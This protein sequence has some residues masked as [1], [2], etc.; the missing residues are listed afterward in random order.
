MPDTIAAIATIQ[1]P[2][3]IG[4]VRLTGPDTRR[5]L[6]GVFAPANGRPMS[7]QTPRKLVFGR[8]LDRSGGVIDEALAVL[9]PGPNSYTGEDCAEIHCHGSPVVLDEVLAAAFARGARQARGGEF[10]QRAFLSGRMDLIQAE[11]V[12][13]LIDAESAGAARNAV[14]QLQGRM[15]RSVGGIYDALMDVVSRFYAI[16]D[17]PDEEIEPLQQAQIEQTL[18]ESAERL[19][20][21]LATFSRGRLLKSGVPAVILGK[22]NAGKSSLLNALLGYDRA[23]VT[24]IAGTTRDTVEEKVLVGSVLLR[25]CDTAGIRE[26]ADTVE[27][28]GVERAQQAAQR[29][30]LALLVLDGSAPLT[31]EDEEAIAAARRARRM[32][33][34]VNKAD[35][36]QVLDTAALRVR[37]GEVI[38]ISARSGAGVDALCRAV[39]E[40]FAGGET[41]RGELLTNARQA[42]SAQRALDA[43]RRAEQALRSGLSPDAVLTDAEEALE[44]LAEF[45]GERSVNFCGT[46]FFQALICYIRSEKCRPR[47][48]DST[49]KRRNFY[50]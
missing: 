24:D 1:A 14:G 23:I 18:A 9:F 5:I 37:F 42:E 29:A 19:D 36:P 8:A 43:V 21:L 48:V 7:A 47:P 34:L 38:P 49:P 33:V 13:D 50:E 20:A 40:L 15:S 6:D 41:P 27:R 16:V 11:S 10:T 26:A 46:L 28:L 30:E 32:L 31:R 2:S 17:Y 35:L 45:S 4:I 39:E 12:A 44:A 3:A 22:P 25:L